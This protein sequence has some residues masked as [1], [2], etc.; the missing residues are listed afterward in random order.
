M[1]KQSKWLNDF[2][3]LKWRVDIR[4]VSKSGESI[5]EPI[6]LF[7]LKTN[8]RTVGSRTAKFETNRSDIETLLKTLDDIDMKI[9]QN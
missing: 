1:Y 9:R 8:D 3:S 5:N 2:E 4:V 7:E 6:A